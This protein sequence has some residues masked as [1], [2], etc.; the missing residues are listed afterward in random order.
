MPIKG[1]ANCFIV[2]IGFHEDVHNNARSRLFFILFCIA[3]N[4]A[5]FT[6]GCCNVA[7]TP[8]C[9]FWLMLINVDKQTVIW[10][11]NSLI[12]LRFTDYVEVVR[13][14][15]I[16]MSIFVYSKFHLSVMLV[17]ILGVFFT[18]CV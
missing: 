15:S 1:T 14:L 6:R 13:G 12:L 8:F 16:H 18:R 11:L 3:Q 10:K 7:L 9:L 5:S 4:I 17:T 2:I